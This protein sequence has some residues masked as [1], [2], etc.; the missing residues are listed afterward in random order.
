MTFIAHVIEYNNKEVNKDFIFVCG[1]RLSYCI[2]FFE[3][4]LGFNIYV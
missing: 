2:V 1:E 4:I 3:K